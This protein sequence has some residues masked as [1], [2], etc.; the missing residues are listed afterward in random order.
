MPAYNVEDYVADALDSALGQ[1]WS[2]IEIIVV[3]D[4]STDGTAD[5]LDRYGDHEQVTVI[6]QENQ[7][8]A[9]AR[10]RAYE[11]SSGALVKFFDGDDLLSPEFVERQVTRLEG[12]SRHVASA[13]W[14]RFYDDPSEATFEPKPVWQDMDPVDWLVTAWKDA[15]PM[16]QPALWLIPCPILEQAG[17]W[18][19][20]LSLIDDFEFGT[21]LMTHSDGVRFTHGARLYYRSGL[22]DSLSGQDRREHVESAFCSLMDGTQHL[23][24]REDSPRTRRAAANMLQDFIYG[25]Y[26]NHPDLRAKMRSRIEELGGSDLEPKGPPGFE[27]LQPFLGWKLARRAERFAVR[28]GLNR[29]SI[30]S[31]MRK[32]FWHSND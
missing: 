9:A 10:N 2:E 23:L 12:S 7:G 16:M 1:T 5:V 13:E 25:R 8:A 30:L 21:R 4:G 3:N 27:M 24:D 19:E 31:S 28:N 22:D 18:N 20:E 14:A 17:L 32:L 6:H 11:N 26:P 15:R 29:S